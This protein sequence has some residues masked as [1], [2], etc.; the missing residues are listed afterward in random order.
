MIFRLILP[1]LAI[2]IALL[3]AL[4]TEVEARSRCPDGTG[5]SSTQTCRA[6]VA[7]TKE[8]A[9]ANPHVRHRSFF[10]IERTRARK[11]GQGKSI[12]K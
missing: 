5:G 7:T 8:P 11:N 6:Q 2:V 1:F 3:A 9:K 12:A 10:V 4:A